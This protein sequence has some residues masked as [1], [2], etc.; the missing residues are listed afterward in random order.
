M[1]H[2]N[3][4]NQ[5]VQLMLP[6]N[7]KVAIYAR[8]ATKARSTNNPQTEQLYDVAQQF[9]YKQ[10]QVIVYEDEN[11]SGKT[12]VA[13]RQGLQEL[14]NEV[15]QGNI[16]AILVTTEEK[17]FR[18]A[19]MGEI[20]CCSKYAQ[21]TTCFL[22]RLIRSMTFKMPATSLFSVFS[23]SQLTYLYRKL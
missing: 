8:V 9:G 13:D 17:L 5:P 14:L 12:R 2:T 4:S 6:Q 18:D 11:I 7:G 23:A 10:E 16:H 3:Q 15:T 21:S 22:S 1:T 19:D 20:A